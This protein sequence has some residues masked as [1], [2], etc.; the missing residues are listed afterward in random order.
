[1]N[2]HSIFQTVAVSMCRPFSSFTPL[3]E[4]LPLSVASLTATARLWKTRQPAVNPRCE[5]VDE[6]AAIGACSSFGKTTTAC[7]RA[8]DQRAT[9]FPQAESRQVRVQAPH[10]PGQSGVAGHGL[11]DLA[12]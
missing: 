6:T 7:R 12:A 2:P 5:A 1:M 10:R 11:F 8:A 4:L 9:A 3:R